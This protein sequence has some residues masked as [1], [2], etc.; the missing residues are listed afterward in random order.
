MPAAAQQPVLP[1]TVVTATRIESRADALVSDLVLIDRAAIEASAARSL[2][3][4]LAREAGLQIAS[5]GGFGQPT[6]VFTRGT[7]GRHTLLLVDG[8]RVGSLY[9]AVPAWETI[10]LEAIERIEVL[11]GPASA[12]YGADAAGGVVQVFTRRG[13]DGAHPQ[14]ALTAGSFG[15]RRGSASVQ[16]GQDRIRYA[17]GMQQLTDR[18]VSATSPTAGG[19]HVP[20]RDGIQ[21]RSAQ[22]SL[23]LALER[24]WRVE[25][26]FLYSDGRIRFDEDATLDSRSI[27]RAGLGRVGLQGTV[28]PGWKTEVAV[29]QSED[30]SVPIASIYS[31][32]VRGTQRDVSWVNTWATPVG[33]LMGGLEHRL[34][35]FSSETALPVRERLTRAG[36]VGLNGQ[37]GA[38]TWQVNLRRDVSS[39]YGQRN[40]ALAGYGLNL[41]PQ[42]RASA[43]W[44][45]TFVAPSFG[46][47]YDPWVGNASLRPEQGLS[48]EASLDWSD[49]GR[50]AKLTV[51]D[52]RFRDLIAYD[53]ASARV[54]NVGKARLQ[55]WT[56]SGKTRVGATELKASLDHLVP[57]DE[58][59]QKDLVRRARQLASAGAAWQ[60]GA[61]RLGGNLLWV[62]ERYNNQA[63][64]PSG[65]LA[66]YATL[67]LFA[68]WRFATDYRLQVKVNNVADRQFETVRGYTQPGRAAYLTLSWEPR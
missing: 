17:L 14:V 27:V 22:G 43:S 33:A 24:D 3:E 42:W 6:S 45:Q 47:L 1:V 59:L 28:M 2:P 48:R 30:T 55:G 58:L 20:D 63:N 4:L 19:S 32:A 66:P 56:L 49:E 13:R 9:T 10:P 18:G 67:D 64:T 29:G 62:G 23:G 37:Q 41:T 26:S 11:K 12:L 61:W 16:G 8:M 7:N 60:G 38:S 57:R 36:F 50:Q 44:G 40:T 39:V 51:Y 31:E 15:H 53:D 65:R 68:D 21:Q 35:E 54:Q 46:D 34:Q 5:N 52:N 25:A